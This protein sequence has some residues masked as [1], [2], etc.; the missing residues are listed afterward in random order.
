M[1]E[2]LKGISQIKPYKLYI[3]EFLFWV[4]IELIEKVLVNGFIHL[5]ISKQTSVNPSSHINHIQS[6]T[7][8]QVAGDH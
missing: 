2:F 4:I 3:E 6:H 7:D 5:K 1:I 8:S